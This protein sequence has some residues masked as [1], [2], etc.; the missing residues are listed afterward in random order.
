MKY[1]LIMNELAINKEPWMIIDMNELH[2]SCES[3]VH[4]IWMF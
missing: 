4:D 2:L 1:K 3:D